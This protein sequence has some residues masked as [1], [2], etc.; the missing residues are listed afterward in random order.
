[1]AVVTEVVDA[2]VGSDT[3]KDTHTVGVLSPVG[4]TIACWVS[5]TQTRNKNQLKALLHAGDDVER[6]LATGHLSDTRLSA[7]VRRRRRAAETRVPNRACAQHGGTDLP[8]RHAATGIGLTAKRRH[9]VRAG[10]TAHMNGTAHAIVRARRPAHT[11]RV[12]P[13]GL[14]PV[15]ALTRRGF[16]HMQQVANA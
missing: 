10:L 13:A 6:A 1:M 11:R 12:H 4:A 15:R 7:I 14:P 8:S 5:D 3:H 2:V 16:A 9:C